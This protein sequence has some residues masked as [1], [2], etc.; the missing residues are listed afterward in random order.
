M[1]RYFFI[2]LCVFTWNFSLHA[3]N[4]NI[5]GVIN[6]YVKVNQLGAGNCID[7][8]Y[9]TSTANFSVD[10]TVLLIQMQGA[11][12]DVTNNSNFGTI[13]SFNDAGNYEFSTVKTVSAGYV[14]LENK[15][16]K[17]FSVS[18]SLQLVRVPS[19]VNVTVTATLTSTPWNGQIGGI[20]AFF[21]SGTV[22]LNA[23]MDASGKGFRGGMASSN[24]YLAFFSSYA[25]NY[26]TGRGGEKG[27]G[28]S[29][30]PGTLTAGRGASS[31]GGGGGNDINTGGGGGGNAG[32]GGHGGNNF[33]APALL[34]GEGGKAL[35]S[36]INI[37]RIFLGGGG[38]G[39][40]Q[41]NSEGSAGEDGGGIIFVSANAIIGNNN[42]IR[43]NGNSVTT[44][45]GI[46]GAGGGGG[47]G[48]IILDVSS[49][50][51]NLQVN[52]N[53][54][55]GGD[56]FYVPQ[57]HGNGG[58]GG[59]GVILKSGT[60]A[61]PGN[62]TTSILGGAKGNGQCNGTINDALVGGVGMIKLSFDLISNPILV[63]N[64]GTDKTICSGDSIQLGIMPQ[65]GYDY[66]WSN[67]A[68]TQSNP[69]VAPIVTTT[70]ILTVSAQGLCAL[71]ATDT[72]TI[73]VTVLS[74]PQASFTYSF[75]CDGLTTTF[76]NTSSLTTNS[77]WDFGDGSFSS[78]ENP[79]HV[80][81]EPGFYEVM[82]VVNAGSNCADTSIM[83]VIIDDVSIEGLFIP[84]AFTPNNDGRNDY[85]EIKSEALCEMMNIKIFNR[86]GQQVFESDN[87][88]FRW[89]G[90][91]NGAEVP[92]GVYYYIFNGRINN[93]T[94]SVSIFR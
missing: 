68:G 81:E 64:A 42:Q 56:Q 15:L 3:Q 76:I 48:T 74:A 35:S 72:D 83:T 16:L 10:D 7:T 5:S 17:T 21:A 30:L 51:G 63:A 41:N 67:G 69:Y 75:D 46:D 24:Y 79:A 6:S 55:K 33:F 13:L 36:A 53:G 65:A 9:V 25:F 66:L 73:V 60:T 54:G 4:T 78:E 77:I 61:F 22:T 29:I 38:G 47:G 2:L 39:G 43:S 86:W 70:Y 80:F 57:C 45:A 71:T 28:I 50:T 44:A 49:F 32:G 88:Y 82:L 89:D 19:Y 91:L 11:T 31:N 90:K 14:V 40:H 59:G 93:L 27:E 12:I 62:V 34:W 8:L 52:V 87:K 58:G 84:N 85:F 20:L 1:T 26:N 18:G 37:D 94:G 92:D 23:N